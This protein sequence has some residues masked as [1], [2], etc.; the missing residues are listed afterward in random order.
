MTSRGWNPPHGVIYFRILRLSRFKVVVLYR[1]NKKGLIN[2]LISIPIDIF[3]LLKITL[4]K[5]DNGL[6]PLVIY[7]S[8]MLN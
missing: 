5:K 1:S 7:T 2:N 3:T 8:T 6:L 4:I